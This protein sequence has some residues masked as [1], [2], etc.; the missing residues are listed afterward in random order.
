MS[1]LIIC[2]L[3][4]FVAVLL[5][6]TIGLLI[7]A[8]GKVQRSNPARDF[9]F[10]SLTGLCLLVFL[11]AFSKSAAHTVMLVLLVPGL[12]LWLQRTKTTEPFSWK[13]L[14][15]SPK[16][17][18]LLFSATAVITVVL[19][20]CYETFT[21]QEDS[22]NY[23]KI[24][25]AFRWTGI[26]N[27][28]HFRTVYSITDFQGIEPYHYFEMWL[29][30]LLMDTTGGLTHLLMFRVA[31]YGIIMTLVLIGLT[32]VLELKSVRFPLM[33]AFAGATLFL[34]FV[35]NL[36]QLFIDYEKHFAYDAISNPLVRLNFRT[37]WL[38]LLPFVLLVQ[39]KNYYAAL[40]ALLLLPVISFTTAPAICGGLMLVVLSNRWT[41]LLTK[42]Q[43]LHLF[44]VMAFF[45]I[46]LLGILFVF[47]MKG[48]Q[49]L[50]AYTGE[51]IMGYYKAAWKAI[52]GA[53]L[54]EFLNIALVF[55]PYLLLILLIGKGKQWMK[56]WIADQKIYLVVIATTVLAGTILFQVASFMNNSYQFAYITYCMI[57]LCIPPL[58]KEAFE[59]SSGMRRTAVSLVLVAVVVFG[60][61]R[62]N[63]L[64]MQSMFDGYSTYNGYKQ[65]DPAYLAEIKTHMEGITTPGAYI[66]DTTYYRDKYYSKRLP[67]FYFP[68]SAYYMA[69]FKDDSYQ[70]CFSEPT[71]IQY[72]YSGT[73]RDLD[74]LK[75]ATAASLFHREYFL[76]DGSPA[77]QKGV[78]SSAPGMIRAAAIRKFNV[79]YVILTPGVQ[80]DAEWS[81]MIK[82][83]SVDKA[84]GESIAWLK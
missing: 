66:G 53:T 48:V 8:A 31:A 34:F 76:E 75:R 62:F 2:F 29:G 84:T 12:V 70:Y 32:A 10:Q 54:K 4:V 13:E 16:M 19:Y 79:A 9:F 39:N 44:M 61:V 26:E 40:I 72:G 38:F 67:D 71:S 14:L 73:Q 80:P 58:W 37:Y 65:Y 78:S 56:T 60:A 81:S 33:I 50:Y 18:A 6:R 17:L 27:T 15:P 47:R 24:A 82:S 22:Y 3:I 5:M 49:S 23:L 30:S 43:C 21:L 41:K 46:T 74:F 35:P 55:A 69:S 45:G 59:R 25:E 83:V 42:K 36:V 11:Y 7:F 28:R 68:G 20:Y 77:P 57:A 63:E 64:S 52:I 51:Y 1:S